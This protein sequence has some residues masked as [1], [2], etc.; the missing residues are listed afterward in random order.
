MKNHSLARVGLVWALVA[1]A[2]AEAGHEEEK[3]IL[4]IAE[5]QGWRLTDRAMVALRS[6]DL[7]TDSVVVQ[8]LLLREIESEEALNRALEASGGHLV[9]DASQPPLSNSTPPAPRPIAAQDVGRRGSGACATAQSE[10]E[11][12]ASPGS[13]SSSAAMPSLLAPLREGRSEDF[14]RT[15][16]TISFV[17]LMSHLSAWNAEDFQTLRRFLDYS[18]DQQ[19]SLILFV[20]KEQGK[21]PDEAASLRGSMKQCQNSWENAH[22]FQGDFLKAL[23]SDLQKYVPVLYTYVREG[24]RSL[25]PLYRSN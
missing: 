17:E 25:P 9:S 20:L 10:R 16:E 2:L 21:E 23:A 7:T 3:Y 5:T 13:S 11:P 14:I 12:S 4:H 24:L 22:R 1:G 8:G 18:L 19:L 15:L 6:V